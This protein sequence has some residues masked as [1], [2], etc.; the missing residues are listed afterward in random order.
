MEPTLYEGDVVI[1]RPINYCESTPKEGSI[2]VADHPL[3]P[4]TLIIKRLHQKNALG[5]ELRGDNEKSSIDSRQF[6]LVSHSQIRG[7]VEKIIHRLC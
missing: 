1:Y 3:D 5:L 4:Q 7:I 6:G 2:V